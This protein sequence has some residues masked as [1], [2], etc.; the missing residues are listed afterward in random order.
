MKDYLFLYVFVLSFFFSN[1]I[2]ISIARITGVLTPKVASNGLLI[3]DMLPL[4]I[5][6]KKEINHKINQFQLNVQNLKTNTQTTLSCFLFQ[7]D[8]KVVTATKAG[9]YTKGLT[10]GKYIIKPIG[11]M[12]TVVT[13]Q[14]LRT[15]LKVDPS[16]IVTTFEVTTGNELYFYDYER[17]EEDFEYSGHVEDIEFSL[18]EPASGTKTI[19]FNDIPINCYAVQYKLTCN[20]YSSMFPN[21]RKSQTYSV[22]IKD[23]LGNKKRNYFVLPVQITLKYL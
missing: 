14:P 8:D 22:Y 12:I 21:N 10:P 7:F 20:L 19:Y 1:D 17:K 4:K 23:S 18:F 13:E 6:L 16:E 3:L 9:C 11:T 2:P 15:K 5:T